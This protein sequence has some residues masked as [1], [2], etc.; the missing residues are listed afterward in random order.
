MDSNAT[1]P[2]PRDQQVEASLSREILMELLGIERRRLEE[3]LRIER[4]RKIV[5]PETTV[6]IKDI[7][8]LLFLIEGKKALPLIDVDDML[9]EMKRNHG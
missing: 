8:R 4:E 2:Q 5:F 3:A 6:I 1:R 7:E 9:E